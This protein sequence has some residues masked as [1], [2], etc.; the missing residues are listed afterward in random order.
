MENGPEEPLKL[1]QGLL[2]AVRGL[3]VQAEAVALG[4]TQVGGLKADPGVP[5]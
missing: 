1:G 3:V 2:R 5:W 4:M